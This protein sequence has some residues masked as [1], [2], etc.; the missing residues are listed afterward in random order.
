MLPVP[1]DA[2]QAEHV[3]P[4]IHHLLKKMGQRIEQIGGE[5][6]PRTYQGVILALDRATEPLD[7][8]MAL[9]RHLEAV[10]TT[11]AFRTA[12]NNVQGPV[13]AFYSSIPLNEQLWSAVKA[14]NLKSDAEPLAGVHKRF[15]EKTVAGFRRAGADLDA[16]GKKK[17]EAI[18]VALAETTTKFSENVLDA[19]NAYELHVTEEAK[20]AGL[21]ESAQSAAR[22]SARRKEKEGWRFTLQA[23]SYIAAMTYLDDRAHSTPVVGSVKCPRNGRAFRQPAIACG[24]FTIAPRKGSFAR[25]CRL[26]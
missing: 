24:N 17:L 23:P 20:L 8:A 4:A 10:R 18:E 9:V 11:P 16:E 7:Y 25:L 2:I 26:C 6:T 1:F 13:S 5:S 12:H 14:V 19:T 22:E 3:E 21:P 15:L